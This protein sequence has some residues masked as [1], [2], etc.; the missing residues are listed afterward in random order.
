MSNENAKN[1]IV[2]KI[3]NYEFE[4]KNILNNYLK[5]NKVKKND[6]DIL[7]GLTKFYLIIIKNYL[8]RY[9]YSLETFNMVEKLFKLEENDKFIKLMNKIENGNFMKN[10]DLKSSPMSNFLPKKNSTKTY[11]C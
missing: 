11:N 3:K 7:N 2:E 5:Q 10:L 1:F 6:I 9:F 4:R 8:I